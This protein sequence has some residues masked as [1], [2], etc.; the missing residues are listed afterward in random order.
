MSTSALQNFTSMTGLS[1]SELKLRAKQL[2]ETGQIKSLHAL[3]A[4]LAALRGT[5][6]GV[7]D[8]FNALTQTRSVETHAIDEPTVAFQ[9]PTAPSE[10]FAA[11]PPERASPQPAVVLDKA[12]KAGFDKVKKSAF[13]DESE[14]IMIDVSGTL[15]ETVSASD[16]DSRDMNLELLKIQMQRITEMTT[17]YT[18]ILNVDNAAVDGA[19]SN[20]K[21]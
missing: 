3:E 20:L 9:K 6:K 19:I 4:Q 18:N 11:A 7:V 12:G 14:Q 21:A 2:E 13:L 8:G 10:G 17:L 15:P 16:V 1:E 5:N